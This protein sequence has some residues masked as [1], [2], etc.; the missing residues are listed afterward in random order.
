[1]IFTIATFLANAF[2]IDFDLAKR[3]ARRAVLALIVSVLLVVVILA[4][5]GCGRSSPKLNEAEIQRGE[6]AVREQNR[7]ELE[8]ILTA[9]EVREAEIA[10]EVA[11][12]KAATVNAIHEARGKYS[13]M[14]IEELQAEFERGK[15]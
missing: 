9:A 5:R 11:N 4:F 3:W 2:G 6:Q 14:S 10:G 12:S 1:M 13:A 7:K 15:K 8:E